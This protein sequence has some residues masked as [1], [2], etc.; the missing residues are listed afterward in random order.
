M[1]LEE[2]SDKNIDCPASPGAPD[3]AAGELLPLVG[4]TRKQFAHEAMLGISTAFAQIPEAMAFAFLAN[5]SPAMSMHSSWIVAIICAAS[6]GQP[7]IVHGFTGACAAVIMVYV[8]EPAEGRDFGE[9]TELL[10]PAA[11]ICGCLM[12]VAWRFSFSKYISLIPTTIMIGFCN[13]LAIVIGIAQLHPFYKHGHWV[14]SR[15]FIPQLILALISAAIMEGMP[16]IN[17]W[18]ARACPSSLVAIGLSVVLEFAVIRPANYRCGTIGDEAAFTAATAFPL[19]FFLDKQ[20]DI[21]VIQWSKIGTIVE[22]GVLLFFV[23][24]LETLMTIQEINDKLQNPPVSLE[25]NDQHTLGMS[26]ANVVSA[27][28]GGAGGNAMIGSSTIVAIAGGK[29][30]VSALVA[31]LVVMIISLGA[32]PLLNYIPLASL[33]GIMMV[34]VVHTFKWNSLKIILAAFKFRWMRDYTDF[35]YR[36]PVGEVVVIVTVTIL[37][38][39]TNLVY[40]VIFGLAIAGLVFAWDAIY[41]ISVK[42]RMCDW[43]RGTKI[44]EVTGPLH[45]AATTKFMT[46]FD[47]ANDPDNVEVHFREAHIFDFSALHTLDVLTHS[48]KVK[49]KTLKCYEFDPRGED[50]LDDSKH[51]YQYL[52]YV[53]TIP[54]D[55][56]PKRRI[57]EEKERRI[58]NWL[59]TPSFNGLTSPQSN[60]SD[61]LGAASGRRQ[62]MPVNPPPMQMYSL[63]SQPLPEPVNSKL[64][65]KKSGESKS[66]SANSL[67]ALNL[68]QGNSLGV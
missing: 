15:V 22:M 10:F 44:Y 36:I 40:A 35:H 42:V 63:H 65:R 45:F 14:E 3:D 51:L 30:R 64:R 24:M 21:S 16:R 5:I 23:R 31:A 28:M 53:E 34:V 59:M 4:M 56:H 39:L 48:Y 49:G 19:P 2:T 33:S 55:S 58:T 7:G 68:E 47:A 46:W 11:G 8:K 67:S 54:G 20:F 32:Y 26:I 50:L 41:P 27:F 57:G 52:H 62:T 9:G 38:V 29:T 60:N 6:G 1:S 13:G 25:T 12:L 37:T 66:S 17:H 61:P 18:T 43:K